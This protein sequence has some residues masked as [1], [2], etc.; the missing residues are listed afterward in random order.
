MTLHYFPA[1]NIPKAI[2]IFILLNSVYFLR[3][4]NLSGFY[5]CDHVQ[6]L[7]RYYARDQTELEIWQ[8]KNKVYR[9]KQKRVFIDEYAGNVPSVS[10]YSG[11]IK[12]TVILG[13]VP[14]WKFEGSGYG[15]HGAY[16][17]TSESGKTLVAE[18]R[19]WIPSIPRG[20]AREQSRDF[21]RI[22]RSAELPK[23]P[24]VSTKNEETRIIPKES[25]PNAIKSIKIGN[26]T[27]MTG[28]L[29]VDRFRNG[30]Q[31]SKASNT[32]EWNQANNN[33]IPAWCFY[34][35]NSEFGNA[36][37]RLYNW[38]AINDKRGLCPTGW[39]VPSDDEWMKL[40]TEL[41]GNEFAGKKMQIDSKW[42]DESTY[43]NTAFLALP[44]G[45]RDS[46]GR[47]SSVGQ[48]GS[49]W[50]STESNNL[51]AWGRAMLV[52]NRSIKKFSNPKSRGA[53]VICLKDS[54]KISKSLTSTDNKIAGKEI[55]DKSKDLKNKSINSEKYEVNEK[56]QK[57]TQLSNDQISKSK[58]NEYPSDYSLNRVRDIDSQDKYS[59]KFKTPNILNAGKITATLETD[60]ISVK[61]GNSIWMTHNLN[62]DTFNNGDLIPHARTV[63]QWREAS[64]A[65]QPA[66]CYYDNDTT[67]GSMYGKL[68]N[69]YAV[70]DPRGLAPNGW[71]VASDFEW[72]EL[73]SYCGGAVDGAINMK[74]NNGWSENGYGANA[75]LFTAMP[76]GN[77]T[78]DNDFSYA[79]ER[80]F[81]WTST[82]VNSV[83]ARI[84]YMITNYKAVPKS[85]TLKE[86]GM[87][88]R[89]VKNR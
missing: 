77:R 57:T 15:E 20:A 16:F 69:W 35:N 9:Y 26:Q 84:R 10:S 70:N 66:W 85:N 81:W 24:T 86:F 55:D 54:A 72:T 12:R 25:I 29:S 63:G 33:K 37:G 4:Q 45:S 5:K 51:E 46:D 73:I 79:G 75:S 53:S 32:Q 11:T 49:W 61:I 7:G 67:K 1:P 18:L 39:H 65:K 31:I 8:D 21:V 50:S 44:G 43:N 19:I 87:S 58:A 42:T 14:A 27:W 17:L 3:A 78:I 36:Y 82:E 2:L 76:G 62:V 30:E 13:D 47:F 71:H 83:E 56:S 59:G 40:I 60:G 23:E 28:N 48:I 88:V 74:N 89:C 68:Y 64:L 6:K 22:Q 80:G 52:H 38:Y 34:E 41:G